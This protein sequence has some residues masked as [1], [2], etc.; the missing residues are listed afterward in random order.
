MIKAKT[1]VRLKLLGVRFGAREIVCFIALIIL[2]FILAN[3]SSRVQTVRCW[4]NQGE[5]VGYHWHVN[6]MIIIV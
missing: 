4:Y 5:L 1:Q 3:R 6:K 2:E